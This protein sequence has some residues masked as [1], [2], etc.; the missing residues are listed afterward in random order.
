MRSRFRNSIPLV[1]AALFLTL[2]AG[3]PA[4]EPDNLEGGRLAPPP[5]GDEQR[6]PGFE[7]GDG[8]GPGFEPGQR[9]RFRRL[10]NGGP[11]DGFRGGGPGRFGPPGG[12]GKSEGSGGPEAGPLPPGGF[13]G[14][15]EP[16]HFRRRRNFQ[17]GPAHPGEA[18]MPP[19]MRRNDMAGQFPGGGP[20]QMRRRGGPGLGPMGGPGGRGR[21]DLTPLG[22]SEDQKAK[23]QEMRQQTRMKVRELR[24]TMLER[25][26]SLRSLMFS[27]ESS[28]S[29]IRA[30]RREL[31]TI[32]DQI[33]E[34]NLNDLLSIRS[35]LTAEQKKRLPECM[36]D[37]RRVAAEA[38]G[39]PGSGPGAVP[40]GEP[41]G[42]RFVGNEGPAQ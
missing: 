9:R 37:R 38:A 12:L 5:P 17:G 28:E 41:F 27:P 21:L 15:G 4:Q 25:Q 1:F 36:P 22:L 23:I 40:E 24:K 29:Q 7:P 18:D 26:S 31:R 20:R 3:C 16:G 35:L 42:R 2:A 30:S 6:G 14:P 32:Q 13:Q 11:P 19:G 10:Q 34:T 8:R 39:R 33:D